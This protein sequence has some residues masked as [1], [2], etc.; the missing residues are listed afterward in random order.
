M[1]LFPVKCFTCGELIE[2]RYQEYC[3]RV[4]SL[5]EER[6]ITSPIVYFTA[7]S[8]TNTPT[9]EAEVLNALQVD[10]VCCRRHFLTQPQ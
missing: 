3:D 10:A 1:P 4:R 2:P 8:N 6:G 9:V 7:D 5:K